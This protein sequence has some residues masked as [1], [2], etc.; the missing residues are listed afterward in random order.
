MQNII[1]GETKIF[2]ISYFSNKELEKKK[3]EKYVFE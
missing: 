1:I 2:T 3:K